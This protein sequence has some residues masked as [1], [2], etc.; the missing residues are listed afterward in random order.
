MPFLQ[1]IAAVVVVFIAIKPVAAIA[2][3]VYHHLRQQVRDPRL[4]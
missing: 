2:A 4:P 3:L 1:S